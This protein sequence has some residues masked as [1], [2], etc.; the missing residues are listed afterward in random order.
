MGREA[1]AKEQ[2]KANRRERNKRYQ[3]KQEN[4]ASKHE[5][6]R[7][8]QEEL[9]RQ[10]CLKQMD[11][12]IDM[13][14]ASTRVKMQAIQHVLDLIHG[15]ESPPVEEGSTSHEITEL[16]TG[17]SEHDEGPIL[18]GPSASKDG[19]SRDESLPLLF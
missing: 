2:K 4:L 19:N 17:H 8:R 14:D 18:I 1:T 7:A 6:D 11:P 13:V 5:Y 12:L 15:R 3:S 10:A 16:G 9:R